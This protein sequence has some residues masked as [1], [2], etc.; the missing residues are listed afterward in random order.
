MSD[1]V[2]F[3]M[4]SRVSRDCIP[5]CKYIRRHVYPGHQGTHDKLKPDPEFLHD[6]NNFNALF[7]KKYRFR[8][9]KSI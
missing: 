5:F 2:K 7:L 9:N 8:T 6:Y 3:V 4:R 1:L